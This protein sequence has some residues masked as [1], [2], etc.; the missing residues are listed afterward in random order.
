LVLVPAVRSFSEKAINV[1]NGNLFVSLTS[2][3]ISGIVGN[4]WWHTVLAAPGAC[5]GRSVALPLALK[6]GQAFE[7]ILGGNDDVVRIG[8][9]RRRDLPRL[10]LP[11]DYR[12]A[13][14]IT[15][16]EEDPDGIAAR[17]MNPDFVHAGRITKRR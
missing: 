13:G 4:A 16:D 12:T 5:H 3:R 17:L 1:G 11:A 8:W 2:H 15:A 9:R 14:Q 10:D 6:G 7:V